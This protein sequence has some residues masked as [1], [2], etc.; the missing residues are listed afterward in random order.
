MPLIIDLC[1]DSGDD[2]GEWPNTASVPSLPRSRKRALPPSRKRPREDKEE[3]VNDT[4]PCNENENGNNT[5]T[6]S[7]EIAADLEL[8]DEVVVSPPKTRRANNA[9]RKCVQT[10][11]EVEATDKD[12]GSKGAEVTDHSESNEGIPAAAASASSHP[13]NSDSEQ[14]SRNDGSATKHS[15]KPSTS[16][17]PSRRASRWEDRF[18]ELADYSK[19]QGHCNV[20]LR[21]SDNT[22]LAS[23]V[24]KQRSNYRLHIKGKAS[25][26]TT[27]RTQELESLGF[28]WEWDSRGTAW[29]NR[30]SEL[31]DYRKIHG[32]CN[33]PRIYSENSKLATWVATQKNH[34]R[35]HLEGKKSSMTLSR[36]QGLE[37]LGFEWSSHGTAWEDRLSEL[38]DYCKIKGHCNVPQIYSENPK[39]GQWAG[40]QRKQYKLHLEGNKSSITLPR[41]QALES[42]GFEWKPSIG[43]GKRTGKKPSL[44]DDARRVHKKPANSRQGADFQL[45]TAPSNGILRATGYH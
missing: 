21:Y 3:S 22:K 14:T 43:Q 32:N 38:T 28:E 4:H 7:T 40:T 37:S 17:P 5:A 2:N 26:M 41:I 6:G 25:P 34:H 1:G 10:V 20:P 18:S 30:L 13:M 45:E 35:F 29:E 23:W 33:V 15:Q 31:A 12:V 19:I 42:L 9:A 36:I 44:D 39:L 16:K 8:V 11:E 24:K 27:F